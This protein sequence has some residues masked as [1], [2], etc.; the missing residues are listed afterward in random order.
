MTGQGNFSIDTEQSLFHTLF[1][2]TRDV[3]LV[4][5]GGGAVQYQSPAASNVL[6]YESGSLLGQ[7]CFDFVHS[8]ERPQ[9]LESFVQLQRSPESPVPCEFRFWHCNGQWRVMEGVLH[10]RLSEPLIGGIVLT[11]QDLTERKQIEQQLRSSE[12]KNRTLLEAIPDL[13]FFINRQGEV[14][15]F[16]STPEDWLPSTQD[17]SEQREQ[18]TIT[19]PHELVLLTCS[20][21]QQV[22]QTMQPIFFECRLSMAERYQD[23]EVRVVPSENDEAL[24]IVRD[25]TEKNRLQTDLQQSNR[26]AELGTLVASMGHEINNPLTYMLGHLEEICEI[27]QEPPSP[28]VPGSLSRLYELS[29]E[30][31]EGAQ[32]IRVIAQDLKTYLRQE[33]VSSVEIDVHEAIDKVLHMLG[34]ELR[35]RAQLERSYQPV[36]RIQT[37]PGKLEQV[38]LNLL[39]N[40][41]QS[42][43][44]VSP[45]PQKIKIHTFYSDS[46]KAV[47]IEISDTGAGIPKEHL[48]HI[49]EPFYTTKPMG[50][51][52]GLGLFVCHN[53]VSLQGGVLNVS[54]VLGE[55]TTFTIS[56]PALDDVLH[57]P[58]LTNL[59]YSHHPSQTP[60]AAPQEL[61]TPDAA[62]L[63]NPLI[64]DS[65][66]PAPPILVIDDEPKVA[67]SLKRILRDYPVT[68]ANSGQEGLKLLQTFDFEL[69]FCDILMPDLI[70]PDLYQQILE[71]KPRYE[72]RFLFV[73][74][75]AFTERTRAFCQEAT[76]PILEKPFNRKLIRQLTK[77]KLNACS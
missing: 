28:L 36:P 68:I 29:T 61:S 19:N 24:A 53:I 10:N 3:I 9:L 38:F 23:Y 41:V 1:A 25:I 30:A 57:P 14:G 46:D 76:Q 72:N 69:V 42:L 22:L 77:E 8:E 52:T 70:G 44:E 75:G 65:N 13:M 48:Q 4:L 27:L 66:K 15:T 32:R 26:M 45:R 12:A 67:K 31:L 34:N 59:R 63:S 60:Q 73:T 71:Q 2:H 47:V 50:S 55:G 18:H 49:F 51:G 6:G 43:P 17:S 33:A 11:M 21:A 40:A 35:Y 64:A 37:E 5:T 74:G 39:L 56:L 58:K 16:K 54:S 7:S 20:H 62:L